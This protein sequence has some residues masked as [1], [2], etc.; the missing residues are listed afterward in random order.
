[1][2]DEQKIPIDLNHLIAGFA[3]EAIRI[4]PYAVPFDFE[5]VL[6]DLHAIVSHHFT[7]IMA[8]CGIFC[9]DMTCNEV[10][11]LIC[12]S[13][14]E[15]DEF[16]KWNIT[17]REQ[18]AGQTS[19]SSGF[20]MISR[21]LKQPHPDDDFVDLDALVGNA[22]RLIWKLGLEQHED[23]KESCGQGAEGGTN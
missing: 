12:Y 20:A 13:L 17:R 2:T 14:A 22:T 3:H 16:R 6:K 21:Y 9:K 8:D 10:R 11:D 15:I 7:E 5:K 19:P 1:M 23:I 4:S 18:A